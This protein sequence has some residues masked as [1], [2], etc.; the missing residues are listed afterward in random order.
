MHRIDH[1]SATED[2]KFTP[3][4]PAEAI[5]A[6]TVTADIMNAF[7]EE[8]AGV[9]EGAGASLN[10]ENNGQLLAAIQ[11]LISALSLPPGV[12][13]DY[14]GGTVPTRFLA[15]DGSAVS[16]TTYAALFAKIGT[17]YGAGDGSTTFNLPVS[18]NKIIKT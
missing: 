14:A 6:T 18:V 12:I 13:L 16:R 7:Q 4:N 5:P 17:T 8:I 15:C 3:G 9:I 1:P 10:K 11:S 2:N